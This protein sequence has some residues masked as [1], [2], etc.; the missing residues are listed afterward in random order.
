MSMYKRIFL[1]CVIVLSIAACAVAYNKFVTHLP[2]PTDYQVRSVVN[3]FGDVVGQVSLATT[4]EAIAVSMDRHYALY[5]HPDLI[6]SWKA[7]PKRALGKETLT[8]QPD[9]I[10]IETV[11]K[12]ADGTY[13]I[14]G[15]IAARTSTL[16]PSTV[17]ESV[18]VR[19]VLTQGPDGW[20]ITASELRPTSR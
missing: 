19:F 16:S 9:R 14:D 8:E 10:N 11:V 4:S 15:A 5:I 13:F 20:Q 6:A 18:P 17:S 7:N 3:G 12:N 2:P 1:F